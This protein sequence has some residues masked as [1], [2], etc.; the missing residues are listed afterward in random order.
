[1]QHDRCSEPCVFR[2]VTRTQLN[3]DLAVLKLD[4]DHQDRTFSNPKVIAIHQTVCE[5][6]DEKVSDRGHSGS[7]WVAGLLWD[8]AESETA[9]KNANLQTLAAYLETAGETLFV[10]Q[11]AE[12]YDRLLRRVQDASFPKWVGAGADKKIKRMD[13]VAWIKDNA[14]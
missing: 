3:P 8:V 11:C 14:N 6:L 4:R 1:L 12:L 9:L 7:H 13:L 10:D 2:I 5:A